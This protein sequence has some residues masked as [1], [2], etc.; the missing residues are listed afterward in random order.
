MGPHFKLLHILLDGIPQKAP[1]QK[2]PEEPVLPRVHPEAAQEVRVVEVWK[3]ESIIPCLCK[4]LLRPEMF[5]E[6]SIFESLLFY[7]AV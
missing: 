7:W 5:M 6:L 4:G 2:D 3:S 1:P